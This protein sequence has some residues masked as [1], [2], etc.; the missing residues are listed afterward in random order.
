VGC[1]SWCFDEV[2]EAVAFE[3][4]DHLWLHPGEMQ[5]DAVV[6]ACLGGRSG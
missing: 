4:V 5:I 6:D 2:E 1:S 3:Y